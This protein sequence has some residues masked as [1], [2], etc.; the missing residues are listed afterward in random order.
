MKKNGLVENSKAL[1]KQFRNAFEKD[2][3]ILAR[4]LALKLT[5]YAESV[6]RGCD[7]SVAAKRHAEVIKKFL[8]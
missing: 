8:N 3:N 4:V 7:N 6:A 1:Q 5:D 2:N